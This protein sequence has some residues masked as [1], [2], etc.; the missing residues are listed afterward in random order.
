[1]K[2]YNGANIKRYWSGPVHLNSEGYG[3]LAEHLL[4]SVLEANLSRPT[5]EFKRPEAPFHDRA[6]LRKSWVNTDNQNDSA[7]HRKYKEDD[8]HSPR[9]GRGRGGRVGHRGY[10]GRGRG[11]QR[12]GYSRSHFKPRNHPY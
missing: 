7:V 12:G 2:F 1:M 8:K 3:H 5:S 11:G 10:H 9:G 4:G 6:K